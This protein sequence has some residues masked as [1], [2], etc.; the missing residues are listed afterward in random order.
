MG[1]AIE[2]AVVTQ[3]VCQLGHDTV[4]VAAYKEL[5]GPSLDDHIKRPGT[6]ARIEKIAYDVIDHAAGPQKF[7][8]VE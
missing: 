7:W 8:V 2:N 4:E 1:M 5:G 3:A 6:N